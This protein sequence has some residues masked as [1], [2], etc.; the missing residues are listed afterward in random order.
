LSRLVTGE[1][2]GRIEALE[3]RVSELEDHS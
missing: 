1:F 2:E 3:R